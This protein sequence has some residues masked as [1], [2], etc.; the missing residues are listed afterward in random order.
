VAL[1]YLLLDIEAVLIPPKLAADIIFQKAATGK[2]FLRLVHSHT[3]TSLGWQGVEAVSPQVS[4][5][6]LESC[7]SRRSPAAQKI[8]EM[9][10]D[11][12]PV[13]FS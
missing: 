13:L 9:F 2:L 8:V 4:M 10:L 7:F 5:K 3:F 1:Y 6:A 11:F 12:R